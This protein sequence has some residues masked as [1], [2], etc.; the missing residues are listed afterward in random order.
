MNREDYI[1]GSISTRIYEQNLLSRNDLERLNDYDSL[2]EVLNALNDTVYRDSIAELNRPEEYEKILDNELK[3]VYNLIEDTANNP[4]I[5]QFLR[6][7]YNFHNLKVLVKEVIQKENHAH[8]YS[9]LGNID[10]AYIKKGLIDGEK[11]EDNFLENL[12]IEGYTPLNQVH[13]D[14]DDYLYYARQALDKY[15]ETGNPKDIDT[16]LDQ[17]Y[18]DNLLYDADKLGL[19]R[20]KD[21]TKERIDL[22]NVKTLLRVKSQD[23][24]V[25]ELQESLIEGGNISLDKFIEGFNSSINTLVAMTSNDSINKYLINA[26]DNDKSIDENLLDLEK[27]ID[28]H[29]MDYSREA[30]SM[31]FGPEVLMNYVISKETEIKNLRI[32]LVSKLNSLPKEFTIERLRES[33]V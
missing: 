2:D 1:G 16:I 18:Y 21:F 32:I 11:L 5:L 30:K 9:D 6:E 26:I 19:A 23:L 4:W 20:V 24:S 27:S 13:D 12:N 8:L 10:I 22:I 14:N 25:E 3:R 17:Y 15:E 31:T 28:D 7:R 29:F 33:Y